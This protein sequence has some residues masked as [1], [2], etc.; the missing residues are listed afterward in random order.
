ML[1]VGEDPDGAGAA[2]VEVVGVAERAEVGGDAGDGL[3]EQ[4]GVGGVQGHDDVGGG[5]LP[6]WLSQTPRLVRASFFVGDGAVGVEVEP[7]F[8]D[9]PGGV[10][11]ADLVAGWRR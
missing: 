9:Q 6:L 5:G 10:D 8:L 11:L 7:G 2:D 1:G 3:V 4:Q